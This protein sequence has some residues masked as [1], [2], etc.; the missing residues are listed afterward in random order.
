MCNNKTGNSKIQAMTKLF[1]AVKTQEDDGW[2]MCSCGN[3]G[4]DGE[5]YVVTTH[6]LHSTDVPDECT[7][8]KTFAELVARL[9]NEYFNDSKVS[10][11]K[12]HEVLKSNLD[13]I[14]ADEIIKQIKKSLNK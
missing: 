4:I 6:R 10:E 7:D 9:L 12:V 1:K 2:M 5:D 13:E 11:E 8:A 3:S 14:V